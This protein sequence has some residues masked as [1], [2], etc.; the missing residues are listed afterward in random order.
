MATPPLPTVRFPWRAAIYGI[1]ILYIGADLYLFHGPLSKMVDRMYGRGIEEQIAEVPTGLIATVNTWPI[2]VAD[3][4]RGVWEYCTVRG[5]EIEKL[6]PKRVEVIRAVV[7]GDLINDLAVWHFARLNPE[8][9]EPGEI[10]EA[11]AQVRGHFASEEMFS[12][13]L[14]AQGMDAASFR[15]HLADQIHQ[16]KWLE[17]KAAPYVSVSDE[18]IQAHFER[19]EA[20]R[21]I[22]ER[23]RARQIFMATLDKDPV[24]V[25]EEMAKVAAELQ[26]GTVTFEEAAKKFSEDER[27]KKRAGDLGYFTRQ[28]MPED[29]MARIATQE[30]GKVGAPFQTELGWH[31][32]EVIDHQ[33]EREAG[34]E[35]V[36]DEIAT[37]LESLKRKDVIAQ[38]VRDTR[39]RSKIWPPEPQPRAILEP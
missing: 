36:R 9:V 29:F 17:A 28:R 7:L 21:L 38:I 39:K 35:E 14:A 31:L 18:E 27:T 32:V 2:T 30:V 1:A 11:L 37:H 26:K 20:L 6:D 10:D 24:A 8:P 5:M 4:D 25:G 22:P 15:E 12:E 16:R 13:R 23:W 3:L 19:D 33:A 34:I